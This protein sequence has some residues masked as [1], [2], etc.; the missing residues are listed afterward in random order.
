MTRM[1]SRTKNHT[2][3]ISE[4]ILLGLARHEVRKL[5]FTINGLLSTEWPPKLLAAI[6]ELA[7]YANMRTPDLALDVLDVLSRVAAYTRAGMTAEVAHVVHSLATSAMPTGSLQTAKTRKTSDAEFS[8]LELGC[9]LARNI[10]Y[11]AGLYLRDLAVF[12]AGISILWELLRSAHLNKQ[13]ELLGRVEEAFDSARNAATRSHGGPFEDALRWLEFKR[14]DALSL[15]DP[16]PMPND[17]AN[18]IY[19]APRRGAR[20]KR[21]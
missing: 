20:P 12:D 11:D 13:P 18:L 8:A 7:P 1:Q 19:A 10:A 21:A 9:D 16:P 3:R 4:E 2:R 6:E 15:D 17:I 5:G 14:L